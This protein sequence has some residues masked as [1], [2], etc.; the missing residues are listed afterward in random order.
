LKRLLVAL[1]CAC[2]LGGAKAADEPAKPKAKKTERAR[3]PGEPKQKIWISPSDR[4]RLDRERAQSRAKK[5][6][7]AAK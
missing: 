2:A 4:E 6:K 7:A 1:A 3:K 5:K